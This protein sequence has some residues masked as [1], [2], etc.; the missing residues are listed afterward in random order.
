VD[1][2]QPDLEIGDFFVG[3]RQVVGQAGVGHPD[4]DE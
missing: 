2:F 1:W 4:A 3:G